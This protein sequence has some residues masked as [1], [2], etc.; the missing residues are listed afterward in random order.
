MIPEQALKNDGMVRSL[1]AMLS[2]SPKA[3]EMLDHFAEATEELSEVCLRIEI[4][5]RGKAGFPYD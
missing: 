5:G 3:K 2:F 4:T 1:S